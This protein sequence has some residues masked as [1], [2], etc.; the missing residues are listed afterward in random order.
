M[1]KEK[2]LKRIIELTNLIND[3]QLNLFKRGFI[4][5]T[6]VEREYRKELEHLRYIYNYSD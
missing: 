4:G 2:L 1:N 6:D 5:T 3:E